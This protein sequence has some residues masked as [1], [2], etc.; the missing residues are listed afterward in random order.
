MAVKTT[1]TIPEKELAVQ[2]F[3]SPTPD[4]TQKSVSITA[5]FN[6]VGIQ[7][8]TEKSMSIPKAKSRGVI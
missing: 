4:S 3:P 5:D 6:A 1:V 7:V 2:T 8:P